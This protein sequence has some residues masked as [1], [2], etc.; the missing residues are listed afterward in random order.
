MSKRNVKDVKEVTETVAEKEVVEEMK[1]NGKLSF[2]E[3]LGMCTSFIKGEIKPEEF[4]EW[5]ETI[6]VRSYIPALDK[7]ALL[8]QCTTEVQFADTNTQEILIMELYRYVFFYLYIS[9]YLGVSVEPDDITY[10]NY[11]ILE[12][13]MGPVIEQYAKRDIDLFNSMLKQTFDFY[14]TATMNERLAGIDY[15][16]MDEYT[17]ANKS[18]ME[19]LG[20][21]TQMVESLRDIINFNDPL[22]AKVVE[23]IKKGALKVENKDN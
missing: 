15:N 18:Y 4:S 2:R 12:P 9:G 8:V 10:E 6:N 14:G 11:D 7:L 21:N 3:I 19:E 17:N 22:T 1:L 13:L 20:K 23:E 5:L 16:K